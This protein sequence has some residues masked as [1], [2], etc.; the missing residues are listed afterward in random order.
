[1]LLFVDSAILIE[2]KNI[3]DGVDI[4]YHCNDIRNVRYVHL[5]LSSKNKYIEFDLEKL[6][7]MSEIFGT[8]KINLVAS[9]EHGGC[10]TCGW[11]TSYVQEF[12]ITNP[13]KGISEG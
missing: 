5:I 6:I 2:L 10:D 1:M 9:K 3:Y 7:Q 4:N 12:E 13:S 8:K 11:G